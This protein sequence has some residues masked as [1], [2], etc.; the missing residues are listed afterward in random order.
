M[1][2]WNRNASDMSSRFSPAVMV[3]VHESLAEA[4]LFD[5]WNN[6]M[7]EL[8]IPEVPSR[9]SGRT[10][11]SFGISTVEFEESINAVSSVVIGL[12]VAIASTL[13]SVLDGPE[14]STASTNGGRSKWQSKPLVRQREHLGCRLCAYWTSHWVF[15]LMH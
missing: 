12:S 10:S 3:S 1:F 9:E 14:A 15:D 2:G 4:G 13:S 7:L 11:P 5:A 8:L 6:A